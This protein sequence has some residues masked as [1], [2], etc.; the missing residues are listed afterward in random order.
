MAYKQPSSGS[1][2]KMM[3]SSPVYKAT[4]PNDE[5]GKAKAVKEVKKTEIPEENKTNV[6]TKTRE[7]SKRLRGLDTSKMT[8][9]ELKTY[10]RMLKNKNLTINT[11]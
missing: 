4:D 7:L 8:A 6:I 5:K 11:P 2:F 9:S 1:T 3:G 10:N